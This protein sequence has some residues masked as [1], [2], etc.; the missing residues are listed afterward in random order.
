MSTP[1]KRNRTA[2]H[3]WELACAKLFRAIGYDKVVTSRSENRKRD[4]DKIDLMN[5]DEL[6]NGL[7]PYSIQCK[8]LSTSAPY[9]KLLSEMKDLK[10]A[11][12]VVLHQ[13]TKKSEKGR[14]IETG[15]YASM[16]MEDFMA[17]VEELKELRTLTEL[18]T[19]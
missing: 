15:R 16:R 12:K 6:E 8:T 13:Q 17:M 4:A 18:I 11:I 19:Q 2:G 7:F 3:N 14:F 5:T 9:P 10:G 1:G